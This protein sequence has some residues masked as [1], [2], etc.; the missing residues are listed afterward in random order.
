MYSMTPEVTSSC[1]HLHCNLTMTED[2]VSEMVKPSPSLLTSTGSV[3]MAGFVLISA[4]K[5]GGI[6]FDAM[7]STDDM[8][9]SVC[10]PFLFNVQA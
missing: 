4:S 7:T 9:V 10:Q 6:A 3:S 2:Q 8:A 5:C 1:L